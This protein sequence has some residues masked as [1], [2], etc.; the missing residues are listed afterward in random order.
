MSLSRSDA[1]LKPSIW[2]ANIWGISVPDMTPPTPV[3][4][5]Q[6]SKTNE[7]GVEGPILTHKVDTKCF[8]MNLSRSGTILEVKVR[9]WG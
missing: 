5:R 2:D 6:K 1:I 8:D 9:I 4:C 3:E 7:N